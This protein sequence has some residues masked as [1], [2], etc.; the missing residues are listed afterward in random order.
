VSHRYSDED[1]NNPA[2]SAATRKGW[3]AHNKRLDKFTADLERERKQKEADKAAT[4]AL[5]RRL[6]GEVADIDEGRL[7]LEVIAREKAR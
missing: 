5:L 2:F 6:M 1:L 7:L 4:I 3:R